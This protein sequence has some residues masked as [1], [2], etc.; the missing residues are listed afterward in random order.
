[1][2]DVSLEHISQ[3]IDSA[4]D[5]TK[6]EYYGDFDEFSSLNL[7]KTQ[8]AIYAIRKWLSIGAWRSEQERSQ[9]QESL[10]YCLTTKKIPPY[11]AWLAGIDD[12]GDMSLW[13]KHLF[14]FLYILWQEWF[15]EP[16]TPANLTNYRER[17]DLEFVNHPWMPEAWKEPKY[18]E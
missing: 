2:T 16:F 12:V 14:D 8:D 15:D 11:T 10:R 6:L 1:M 13:E 5:G 18:H 7:I 4:F 3:L 17:I 9:Y